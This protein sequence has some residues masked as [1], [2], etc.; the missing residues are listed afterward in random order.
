[1]S[2][3]A[4]SPVVFLDANILASAMK[5]HL[6]LALAEA[7]LLYPRWSQKVLFETGHAHA[8]IVSG[9]AGRDGAG[10]AARLVT[11]LQAAYPEAS[12]GDNA[13][14][15][16]GVG[17]LPD[18]DDRHVIEAAWATQSDFI[19]TENIKDFPRKTLE[20]LG[21]YARRTSE[22]LGSELSKRPMVTQAALMVAGERL[23]L[24]PSRFALALR[25]AQLGG[26]AR[27]LGLA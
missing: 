1:M 25:R 26:V 11:A 10:E 19:L 9:Q 21:L 14:K 24:T 4:T 23:M 3:D 7:G 17:R 20:P 8:R 27:K 15:P 5:R 18:D 22:F 13:P 6:I 12:A 2:Q 16:D